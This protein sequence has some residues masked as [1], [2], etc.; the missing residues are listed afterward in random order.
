MHDAPEP[1]QKVAP[2]REAAPMDPAELAEFDREYKR[3]RRA[4]TLVVAVGA[5]LP[6]FLSVL[7]IAGLITGGVF[8]AL[9][10]LAHAACMVVVFLYVL[11]RSV[12]PH[13]GKHLMYGKGEIRLEVQHDCPDCGQPLYPKP[14]QF[15]QQANVP[16][17][18]RKPGGS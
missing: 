4:L 16:Y 12:C 13:C 1:P 11:P 7:F 17:G 14:P 2:V 10:Y 15:G 3:A 5:G 6:V 18:Y 9:A 8:M